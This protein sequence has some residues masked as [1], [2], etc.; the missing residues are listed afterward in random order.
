M[1]RAA[2][3]GSPATIWR[4]NSATSIEVGQ[5]RWQGASQQK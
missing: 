2:P 3:S 5:A 1:V 4:M